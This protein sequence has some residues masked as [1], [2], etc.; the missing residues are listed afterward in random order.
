MTQTQ[1]PIQPQAASAN[2]H[3]QGGPAET[4]IGPPPKQRRRPMLWAIG[5]AL[6]ALGGLGAGWVTLTVSDTQSVLALSADVDRGSVVEAHHLV[7]VQISTDPALTPVPADQRDAVIGQRAARDLT[8]G[9]VLS[10][11]SIAE[12]V[13]PGDGQ[14]LVGVALTPAQMPAGQVR[15][16]DQVTIVHTPRPQDDAPDD[17]PSTV[18]A[19]VVDVVV[20]EE[21]GE[22]VVNVT[23]PTNEATRLAAV[24]ATG[25]VA[26]VVDGAN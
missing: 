9:T 15:V 16:G 19:E 2:A 10:A 20:V 26:L 17:A 25:R 5:I 12:E 7:A 23:V 8:A 11:G 14:T 18:Q 13:I 24:V 3:G 22:T 4:P 21:T 1:F 6:V